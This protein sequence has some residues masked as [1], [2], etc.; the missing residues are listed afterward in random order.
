MRRKNKM[1]KN[2]FMERMIWFLA[3][4]VVLLVVGFVYMASTGGFSATG[5]D[6]GVAVTGVKNLASCPTDG[7]T[8]A[9]ITVQNVLNETGTESY[10]MSITLFAK[11]ANGAEEWVADVTDT[12]AGAQ[13]LN[14]GATYVL[15]G[16]SSQS[17]SDSAYIVAASGMGAVVIEGGNAV[18]ITPTK[19]SEAVKIQSKQ[20]GTLKFKAFDNLNNGWIYDAADASA[21]DYETT[22]VTLKSTTGNTTAMAIGTD[23]EI[24]ITL[25][26][27]SVESDADFAD[28][29]MYIA[30]EGATSVWQ[31]PTIKFDGATLTNVKGSLSSDEVIYFAD[32]EYVFKIDTPADGRLVENSDHDLDFQ[33]AARSGVNPT[34]DVEIDFVSIGSSSATIGDVV[35]YGGVTDASSPVVVFTDQDVTL[36]IS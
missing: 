21:T 34:T 20:H 33:M 15:R 29:G 25:K 30:I 28:L 9:T 6:D 2:K 14:C 16:L 12:T 3:I 36:D 4:V 19:S 23:E 5:T 7:D 31:E 11:D 24:D 10:D 32:Y 22:G 17:G 13:T 18:E 35:N 26:V 1:A 27:R 8:S